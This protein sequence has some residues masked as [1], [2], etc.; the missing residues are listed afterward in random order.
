M[1]TKNT[2]RI[3]TLIIGICIAALG[4]MITGCEDKVEITQ[5]YTIMQ[6]VYLTPTELRASFEVT[7]PIEVSNTGKIYLYQNYILLNEPGKGIHVIDNT[8]KKNPEIISFINI[9][10]NYEMA[11]RGDRLFADSYLDLLVIDISDPKNVTLSKRIMDIFLNLAQQNEYYDKENGIVVDFEPKEIIEV[12][13]N[14]FNGSFPSYY[15]YGTNMAVKGGFTSLDMATSSFSPESMPAMQTGIGGSMARFTIMK[16]HLY[17]IDNNSM[18]VFDISNLDNPV[19]GAHLNIG[20]GIETIFPYKDNLFLGTQSGMM[21][22]D[23]TN[24][25]FPR[26]LSTLSHIVSCDPVVVENDIA[27]VTLRGGTG[28]RNTASNQLDVVDISDLKHPKL[29]VTYPMT[30]PHGLGIDNGTLFICEGNA[31]LKV[32]DATDTYKISAN[33]LAYY[34]EFDAFDVIPYNNNLILIGNNGLYQF[35]YSNPKDIKFL[36]MISV[37][38]DQPMP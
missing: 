22:Y 36:S 34:G 28:C 27:Y 23:N 6:P 21:I 24:P 10:G 12:N 1:K 16:D 8:D 38:R 37:S 33:L 35:D 14:E 30:N 25:E 5:K 11:V 18:Q 29:L 7:Q 19:P 32:F 13:E 9:P 4:L 3:A 26:H 20:W 17:S 2:I 31:G 15:Y